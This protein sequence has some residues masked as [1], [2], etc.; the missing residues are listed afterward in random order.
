MDE[1]VETNQICLHYLHY[2]PIE[3]TDLPETLI[4]MHGLTSQRPLFRW[5]NPCRIE[6]AFMGNRG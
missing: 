2:A 3:K 5:I 1:Y 6:P 4:L